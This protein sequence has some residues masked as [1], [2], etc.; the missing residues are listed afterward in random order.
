MMYCGGIELS[1]ATAALKSST[2]YMVRQSQTERQNRPDERGKLGGI[3]LHV[4]ARVGYQ[5]LSRHCP[6]P[7]S[8]V[9]VVIT[10][11]LYNS[12]YRSLVGG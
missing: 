10:R 1:R 12:V 9:K 11:Q 7:I 3:K 8:A 6:S 5:H 2:L 4:L